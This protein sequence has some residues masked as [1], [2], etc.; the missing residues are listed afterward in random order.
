MFAMS[1]RR[2][3]NFGAWSE[4]CGGGAHGLYRPW[5]LNL[6]KRHASTLGFVGLPRC[7]SRFHS[8]DW[9]KWENVPVWRLAVVVVVGTSIN[10]IRS[11]YDMS[12]DPWGGRLGDT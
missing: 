9:V 7:R 1:G 5:K 12:V 4:R 11:S 10:G 6:K 2:W 3:Y 8:K